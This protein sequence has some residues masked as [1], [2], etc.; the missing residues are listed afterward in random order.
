[1]W[2]RRKRELHQWDGERQ[3][4][5]C[6]RCDEMRLTIF[7]AINDPFF[8]FF[9]ILLVLIDVLLW[10]VNEINRY[11]EERKRKKWNWGR[12]YG[13]NSGQSYSRPQMFISHDLSRKAQENFYLDNISYCSLLQ[14][15]RQ[16][17]EEESMAIVSLNMVVAPS[18]SAYWCQRWRA[19]DWEE[20]VVLQC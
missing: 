4:R 9:F 19:V 2:I 10:A 5:V 20:Q 11:L 3:H 18:E 12:D 16:R 17:K 13:K 6:G 8:I 14:R 7:D 1:M 15:K